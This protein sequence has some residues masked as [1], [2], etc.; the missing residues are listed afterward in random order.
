MLRNQQMQVLC[1]FVRVMEVTYNWRVVF[2]VE[3][4]WFW[5]LIAS[6]VHFYAR[7]INAPELAK[8]Q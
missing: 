6:C 1:K 4:S 5:N 8:I 3:K 7:F 2:S